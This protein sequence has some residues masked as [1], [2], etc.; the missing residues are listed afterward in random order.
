MHTITEFSGQGLSH[1][2]TVVTRFSFYL[3]QR[4]P[5][6]E[7]TRLHKQKIT[8]FFYPDAVILIYVIQKLICL[9][10]KLSGHQD[11]YFH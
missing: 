2:H 5:G 8:I 10:M 6:D 4:E 11:S 9:S 3:P 1:V 7:A